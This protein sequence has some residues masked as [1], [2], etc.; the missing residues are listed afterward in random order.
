MNANDTSKVNYD[1]CVVG[2]GPAG[3]IT[4]L[5]FAR[6]NPEKSILLIEYGYPRQKK[7]NPLDDSIQIDNLTNHHAPYDCTNKGLGGTTRTWGGRCVMYDEVDFIDRPVVNGGCTWDLQ[8]FDEVKKYTST[9]A[10]YF[11]C[12]DPLFNLNEI[13]QFR[14]TRIAENFKEGILTDSVIER[15]SMPTRFGKRYEKELNE[16]PNV[17]VR[18]G[19]EA[20]DFSHPDEVGN[21]K[22]L[23]IRSVITNDVVE[24][25]A[26]QF[27]LAAGTQETTRILLRNT[28]VF[29]M[30]EEI[31]SALGRFY[32]C[33]TFGK[34]ASIVF[35]GDPK[36]TDYGFL[37]NPDGTYMRRR[38]QFTSDF[39][40]KNNLLNAAFWLDNPLYYDHKHKNGAMSLMYLA[41]VTPF[42]KNKLAPAAVAYSISKGKAKNIHRHLSNLIKDFP[43]SILTPATIFYKRY[44]YKRKLPGIFFFNRKNT[45][46]LYFHSEQVPV[47]E[48]C[49]ELEA[50]TEK[51][52]IN[53]ELTETDV[54]S[55]I[56]LHEAIDQSLR[57]SNCGELQYWYQKE[58]LADVIRNISKDGL[59][60]IGTTRIANSPKD[61]VVD[62]DLKLW[63][64]NNIYI[65]SSS[66]FPTSGQ[67]NPTFF[68]GAFAAR[69]ANFLSR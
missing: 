21:I 27:V 16:A 2:S 49:M 67:A 33:H 47:A 59:H 69:L 26:K 23:T 36:K 39:L 14:G 8:L 22:T 44:V 32:Q 29:D 42:L 18:Q 58:E 25:N 61:G 24:I 50:G 64:T 15:W 28:H 9:A 1:L 3:I 35:K 13:P 54:N 60:Q 37:H 30:L 20:R 48:N 31:P 56:K 41:M 51:L 68:L 17:T 12:G 57:A 34:I 62:R 11:E 4:V 40:V 53:Y 19:F 63:G 46:A 10:N 6:L 38:L 43:G 66:V 52:I 45:Y 5:E 55:V 7:R 65:C